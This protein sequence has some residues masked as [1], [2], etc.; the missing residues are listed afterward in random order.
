MKAM[1][2][3]IRQPLKTLAGILLIG[4]AVSILTICIGQ[5]IAAS[6]T[7]NDLENNYNTVALTTEKYK[8][9]AERNITYLELPVEITS[10]ISRTA[11]QNPDI[12]K[13]VSDTGRLSAYIPELFPD[14][15]TQYKDAPAGESDGVTGEPYSCAVLE[16]T[17]HE[18]GTEVQENLHQ[19]WINGTDE[20]FRESVSIVCKGTVER[21]IALQEGYPDPTGFTIDVTFRV[22]DEAALA[23]LDLEEGARY[24]IFGMDYFDQDWYLRTLISETQAN[25]EQ[26]FDL[27]KVSD[28]QPNLSDGEMGSVSY[29]P[30]ENGNMIQ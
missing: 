29:Y 22:W 9:D 20:S 1:K 4:V 11:N 23:A 14:N 21:V 17:L 5:Y 19:Q 8:Y 13:A 24:L 27:N 10:W 2:Q 25:F 30:D 6:L 7:R 28:Y 15:Y 3:L 12:I 18:I 26:P 16:I